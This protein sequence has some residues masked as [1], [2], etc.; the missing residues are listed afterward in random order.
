[1]LVLTEPAELVFREEGK[2]RSGEENETRKG[3]QIGKP[4]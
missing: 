3:G 2:K 1:L 4:L